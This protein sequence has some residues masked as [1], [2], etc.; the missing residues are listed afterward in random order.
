MSKKEFNNLIRK[1]WA[2]KP[3]LAVLIDPD[4]FNEELILKCNKSG[5]SCFLVGGSVLERGNL[6]E[7][8]KRIKVLS[9][10]PV[11]LFPGDEQQLDKNADG[12]LL[13]SLLSGRNP[14]YL[15]GKH[16]KAAPLIRKMKLPHL[17]VAYLLV[18]GGRPSS[19]EKVTRTTPLD[20]SNR[21]LI[22]N[23][24]LAAELLGFGAIYLEAGS[25]AKHSISPGLLKAVVKQVSLPLIVGGGINN[26]TTAGALLKAGASMIVLGNA[27]EKDVHLIEYIGRR[28][29]S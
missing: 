17:S 15:I 1:L 18:N 12:I 16:V 10:L 24:A 28:F 14:E 13:L 6:S 8:V 5:V 11:L 27:L 9:S 25:G 19:T 23:T 21:Q 29:K 26:P 4:K 22:V 2:K 3:L 7:T 20:P